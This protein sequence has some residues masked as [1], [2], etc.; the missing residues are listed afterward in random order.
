[1]KRALLAAWLLAGASS[2]AAAL[3]SS[4]DR[5]T[6]G[7]PF[8][9]LGYGARAAGLGGAY[10]AIGAEPESML[11]NPA[12]LRSIEST[13]ALSQSYSPYLDELNF[14]AGAL[15]LRRPGYS[16]G[17]AFQYVSYGSVVET[18]DAGTEVGTFHPN[19]LAVSASVARTIGEAEAGVSGKFIRSALLTSAETWALDAGLLLPKAAGGRLRPAAAVQNIGPGLKFRRESAPLPLTI[20]AGAGFQWDERWLTSADAVF[21]KDNAPHLAAGAEYRFA[22]GADAALLGRL[23]LNSRTIADSV[24]FGGI[25]LGVGAH[26]GSFRMDYALTPMG[27]LG[28]GHQWSLSYYF[29]PLGR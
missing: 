12:S 25:S 10:T 5:G 21:P 16:A 6:A 3:F 8:L 24:G 9:Q 17:L 14:G 23:G 27:L 20:R 1:M 2:P 18:D 15:A 28:L 19:D 11:W 13:V 7:A 4:E 22:L 29:G 26:S